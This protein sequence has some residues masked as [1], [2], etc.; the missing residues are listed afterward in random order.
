MNDLLSTSVPF[1]VAINEPACNRKK[2]FH[3]ALHSISNKKIE[4]IGKNKEPACSAGFAI[5]S[6][7]IFPSTYQSIQ[8]PEGQAT[9]LN[10]WIIAP[11]F[12][13][14]YSVVPGTYKMMTD[15][16]QNITNNYRTINCEKSYMLFVVRG[17]MRLPFCPPGM[18]STLVPV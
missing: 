10:P 14:E 8:S 6:S 2:V 11:S 7:R 13:V 16:K 4:Y 9:R 5:R 17:T 12:C 15:K 18:Q 1:V 3:S